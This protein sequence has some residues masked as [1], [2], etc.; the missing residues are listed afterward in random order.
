MTSR[1]SKYG[2]ASLFEALSMGHPERLV[3]GAFGYALQHHPQLTNFLLEKLKLSARRLVS[4]RHEQKTETGWR[5]DTVVQLEDEVVLKFELKL[6][7]H[8]SERQRDASRAG[9]IHAAIV[10]DGAR[11]ADGSTLVTWSEVAGRVHGDPLL[12]RLFQEANTSA[13]WVLSEIS[14]QNIVESFRGFVDS[15]R[16]PDMYRFLST[17][18]QHL[19]EDLTGY[20]RSRGWSWG[21]G[22]WK[23]Y[24]FEFGTNGAKRPYWMGFVSSDG[25]VPV[26]KLRDESLRGERM[27]LLEWRCPLSAKKVATDVA[28]HLAQSP[29]HSLP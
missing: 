24:G 18:N 26:L 29:G 21:R 4:V 13:S 11:F 1:D 10:P 17:V 23:Y 6:A 14:E 12:V 5:A 19:S 8:A 3:Q 2:E 15:D 22:K 7:A 9:F 16:W 25:S 28:S 27:N 20:G